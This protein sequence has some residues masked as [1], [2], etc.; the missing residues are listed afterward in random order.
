MLVKWY[1]GGE[2]YWNAYLSNYKIFHQKQTDPDFSKTD[3]YK[4]SSY[5]LHQGNK[6]S[7]RFNAQSYWLL[8]K[9]MDSHNIARGRF[10]TLEKALKANSSTNVSDRYR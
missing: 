10:D 2:R 7:D 6:L 5:I 8:T 9:S 3:N 1:K 4:A